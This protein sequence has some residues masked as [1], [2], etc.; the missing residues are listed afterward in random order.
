[1]E[2]F[3][4]G[5]T[6]LLGNKLIKALSNDNNVSKI[7]ALVRDRE[8]ALSIF[9]QEFKNNIGKIEFLT[10][11]ISEQ[12]FGL[13][14]EDLYKIRNISKFY[15]LAACVHLGHS[16]KIKGLLQNVNINGVKNALNLIDSMS[17]LSDFYFIS[18]AYSSGIYGKQIPEDWLNRPSKFRNPYEESKW[19]C[20]NLIKNK[21][22][23]SSIN[24]L[25]IRPSI[26]LDE[27]KNNNR[28]STQT[29]YLFS[30]IIYKYLQ[31]EKNDI[32][33]YGE[34]TSCLNFVFINDLV[35]FILAIRELKESRIFNFV[36]DSNISIKDLLGTIKSAL[37]IQ[38]NICFIENLPGKEF[39]KI[40]ELLNKTIQPFSPYLTI[41][42][43]EW[44]KENTVNI[45]NRNGLHM[46]EQSE[47][48]KNIYLYCEM[49]RE[50]GA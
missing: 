17:N 47:T 44:K 3:V 30:A 26:L 39:T 38:S 34:P 36:S 33:L 31:S 22:S 28:I 40:E 25:I 6:G 15:H 11:D 32:Q 41:E 48:L 21:L 1:M 2:I 35:K 5:S 12:N 10:G 45:M 14:T 16:E 43:I 4:T 13:N 37:R 18:T 29:I 8:R 7:Y 46:T 23:E 20:E 27:L 19:E 24:Y 9:R 42:K 49:L 50:N